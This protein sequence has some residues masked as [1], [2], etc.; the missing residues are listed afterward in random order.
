MQQCREEDYPDQRL[1][2]QPTP[3][4]RESRSCA[5]SHAG[6]RPSRSL[7][8]LQ[9]PGDRWVWQHMAD[10]QPETRTHGHKGFEEKQHKRTNFVEYLHN[11]VRKLPSIRVTKGG[12]VGSAG[13]RQCSLQ[14]Y[15]CC[16]LCSVWAVRL[17]ILSLPCTQLLWKYVCKYS[18]K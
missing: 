17:F 3:S 9:S 2:P 7:G 16:L 5:A 11:K 8:A 4:I 12:A 18:L 15:F 1:T 10:P 13:V 14:N 6:K